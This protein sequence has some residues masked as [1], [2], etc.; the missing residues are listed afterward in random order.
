[1]LNKL[2]GPFPVLTKIETGWHQLSAVIESDFRKLRHDP[3]E[4][5]TRFIQ[6]IVWLLIFGQAMSKVRAIPTGDVP[7]LDFIAPGVLAQGI[8]FMSIFYGIS[9]IWERDAG[10]LH[11][12][13]ITPT[14]RFLLV[15]GR[16]IACGLRG[17]FQVIVVYALS[18]FLEVHL[19]L[20]PLAVLGVLL[21]ALLGGAL[22]S[23]LSFLIALSLKKRERFIAIGQMLTLPL[24]FASNALYPIT[25]MPD[26]I[27][28]LSFLNPLTY[29][30]DALRTLMIQNQ[31]SHFGLTFDFAIT[32]IVLVILLIITSKRYPR[33]LY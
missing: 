28:T 15:L 19:N 18:L 13:L 32:F 14:P 3:A 25:M 30:V 29:Q 20:N 17:L 23:T 24:F 6:P 5:A 1:M 33:I 26:W 31:T 27:Q 12:I 2:A 7:Y 4:I 8:L 10:T 16:A 11:K 9:L 21:M 22:F